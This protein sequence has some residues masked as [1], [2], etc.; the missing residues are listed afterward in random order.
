MTDTHIENLLRKAP[1]PAPPAGLKAQLM[2]NI[3]LPRTAEAR[4]P[5]RNFSLP[6]WRRWFPALAFGMIF[7]TCCIILAVQTS[8]FLELRRENDSLRAATVNVEQLRR[9][10]ADR[11]RLRSVAAQE[12]D[13]LQ[14][15]QEELLKLRGEVTR[16]RAQAQDLAALRA[17]NQRLQAERAAAAAKAGV[18]AEEDPIAA[19]KGEAHR[20]QCVNYLKQISIAARLWAK[21]QEDTLPSNFLTMSNELATPKILTCPSDTARKKAGTWQDFN[22]S[23]VSYEMLS[24]GVGEE[25]PAVVFV[26]CPIHNIVGLV[27]GS[28]H[29]LDGNVLQVKKVDGKFKIVEARPEQP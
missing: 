24:P 7:L 27:D 14:K 21:D 19:A 2:T 10:N 13:R 22:G 5:E 23:S 29:R 15:E 12:A 18:V 26:R 6:L 4:R 28:V 20:V 25:D 1:R 3:A 9:D 16:L 17:E 11:Q 8:Q